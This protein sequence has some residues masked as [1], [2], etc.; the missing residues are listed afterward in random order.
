MESCLLQF[1]GRRNNTELKYLPMKTLLLAVMLLVLDS[2]S[3][4]VAQE[5]VKPETGIKKMSEEEKVMHLI[6]YLRNLDPKTVFIRNGKEYSPEKAA[7]HLKGK[8]EKHK[9]RAKT[10]HAFVDGL[11]TKSSSDEPYM[12]RFPDG[13]TIKCQDLLNEELARIEQQP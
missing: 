11:A 12:I 1:C 3:V 10:A 6:N 13:K 9:K 2:K 7:D 5:K 4:T 8:Y